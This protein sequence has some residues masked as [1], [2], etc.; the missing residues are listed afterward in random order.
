MK[1]L[2]YTVLTLGLYLPWAAVH[3]FQLLAQA[4]SVELQPQ[5]NAVNDTARL[6]ESA[7]ADEAAD[8]FEL[9]IALG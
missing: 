7:V 9:D 2:F 5:I 8:L 4:T 1:N 6:E 3:Y